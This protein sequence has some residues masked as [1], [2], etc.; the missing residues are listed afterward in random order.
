MV[1]KLEHFG[2]TGPSLQ[3][4]RSCLSDRKL[5]VKFENVKFDKSRIK[6]GVP[7]GSILGPLLFVIYVNDTSLASKIFT[8][9]I[10]QITHHFRALLTL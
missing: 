1:Y 9:I 10:S 2:V 4:L 8:A 5:Y 6:T 7:Q 3:L